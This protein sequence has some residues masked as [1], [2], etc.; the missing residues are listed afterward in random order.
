MRQQQ[1][2]NTRVTQHEF[3]GRLDVVGGE[4]GRRVSFRNKGIRSLIF[5][6]SPQ[7]R[8]HQ[9]LLLTTTMRGKRRRK[10]N[11]MKK[12]RKEERKKDQ[13][14]NERALSLLIHELLFLVFSLFSSLLFLLER[15][16]RIQEVS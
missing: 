1:Q 11:G 14:V 16:S 13:D 7:S 6:S 4:G 2:N 15:Q 10:K 3:Y 8:Q 12:E 5:F 9:L